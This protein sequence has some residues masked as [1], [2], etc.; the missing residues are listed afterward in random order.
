MRLW[1]L[2][3]AIGTLAGGLLG[4]RFGWITGVAVGVVSALGVVFFLGRR[5]RR[6]EA[7]EKAP[8][9]E[10]WRATLEEWVDYYRDLDEPEKRRFEQ[11]V[12]WFVDEQVITGPRGAEVEDELKLLVA[13]SAVVVMFGRRGF[14]YPKLRDIVIYD[15]SFD[16]EYGDGGN[17]LG[18]V[19]GQGPILFSARSLRQGFRGEHDGHNVGYHEFAHVL[20]FDQGRADGVPGFMPWAAVHP[21]LKVMHDE[22]SRVERGRSVL[23]QYAAKNEAEF[24]AVATEMFFERP[25]KLQQEQPELYALLEETYGQHPAERAKRAPKK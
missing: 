21:W 12:R 18:M 1:G 4:L 25:E 24:F 3:L 17:I 7:L 22:T 6:R 2:S 20:D 13:A 16:E 23:R 14:R 11:E 15:R 19:H 5:D 10:A 9:P 8:F